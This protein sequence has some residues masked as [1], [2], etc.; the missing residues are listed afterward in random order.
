LFDGCKLTIERLAECVVRL[1]QE[2]ARHGGDIDQERVLAATDGLPTEASRTD[3]SA[4]IIESPVTPVAASHHPVPHSQ[5]SQEH[6]EHRSFRGQLL[7]DPSVSPSTP[8]RPDFR[9]FSGPESASCIDAIQD[10]VA[11]RDVRARDNE[12]P[13]PASLRSRA[14]TYL[15][16]WSRRVCFV[17]RQFTACRV[18]VQVWA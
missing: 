2:K 5:S 1:K 16:L 6:K 15:F 11:R 12:N 18:N 9:S 8:P 17:P 14:G 13:Q 4:N 3:L 10:D 7:P